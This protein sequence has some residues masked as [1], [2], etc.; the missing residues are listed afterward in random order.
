MY[1]WRREI[2]LKLYTYAFTIYKIQIILV[3]I[4]INPFTIY[5]LHIIKILYT[6]TFTI[7]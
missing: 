2:K 3:N 4:K 7:N 6:S 5:N 1:D